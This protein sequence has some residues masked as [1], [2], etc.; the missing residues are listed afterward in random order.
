M[1]I[2]IDSLALIKHMD[3]QNICSGEAEKTDVKLFG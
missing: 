2:I 3:W 1:V